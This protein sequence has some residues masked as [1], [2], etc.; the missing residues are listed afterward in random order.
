LATTKMSSLGYRDILVRE[1]VHPP[2]T[3]TENGGE[4]FP[5]MPVTCAGETWD[6]VCLP[7]GAGD[8][9]FGVAGLK[10]NQDIDTVYTDDDEIPIYLCGSAAI[11]RM[12]HAAN[13]GSIV[14]GDILVAQTIEAAGHVEPLAK[15]LEDT[16]A[17]G[18]ATMATIW[19][20]QVLHVFSLLGRAVETHAS[21]GT[22]TPIKVILSV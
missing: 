18:D 6:D 17:A 10:E 13:G 5:G 4:V 14:A 9:V 3:M 8:S 22:T 20:T 16:V 12:Y 1:G 21:S 2:V 7:D 11:V 19:A 15:A